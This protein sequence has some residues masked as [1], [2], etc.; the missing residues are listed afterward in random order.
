[1]GSHRFDSVCKEIKELAPDCKFMYCFF[2]RKILAELS[3]VLSV[4]VNI[5]FL[6]KLL[7]SLDQKESAYYGRVALCYCESTRKKGL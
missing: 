5:T 1:M 2:H 4:L 6:H 3:S 7:I